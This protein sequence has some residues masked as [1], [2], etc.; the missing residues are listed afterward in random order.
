MWA[1]FAAH[2][3]VPGAAS[4]PL[5][6]RSLEQGYWV[7]RPGDRLR[8]IARRFFPGDRERTNALRNDL[9]ARNPNAFLRGDANA[10]IAG[11]KLSL[12]PALAPPPPARTEA[13]PVPA[14]SDAPR[15]APAPA[16]PSVAARPDD[17]PPIPER[18]APTPRVPAYLDRLIDERTGDDSPAAADRD[19]PPEPLGRRSLGVDLRTEFRDNNSRRIWERGIGV[20]Y[21]RETAL[22]GDLGIEADLR[23]AEVRDR[24]GLDRQRG[25][26]VTLYQ[27]RMPVSADW[28]ADNT[29]GVL[30]SIPPNMIGS[31]FRV[32]LPAP[33]LWGAASY[34]YTESM[35][36]FAYGGRAAR[37]SGFSTQEVDLDETRA[38]IFGV[39]HQFLPWLRLGTQANVFRID[40]AQP[41]RFSV[42]VAAETL[43]PA[44][45]TRVKFAG[46]GDDE[47]H[48]GFWLEGDAYQGFF[49]H[50]FGGY[51]FDRGLAYNAVP[52]VNDERLLYARTDYRTQ[53][54]S[55]S[56]ALDLSQTN[57]DRSA[58]RPGHTGTALFGNANL[59]MSRTITIGGSASVRHEEPRTGASIR[60]DLESET[61]F[62]RLSTAAGTSSF[63]LSRAAVRAEG[64]PSEGSTT[65]AWNHEWPAVW[66]V[67]VSTMLSRGKESS[68]RGEATRSVVGVTARAF[69]LTG[70]YFDTNLVGTRLERRT[71][72]DDNVNASVT[73]TWQFL[74]DWQ[75]QLFA[76]WNTSETSVAD[77]SHPSFRD[78]SVQLAVRYQKAR[79]VPIVPL[80]ARQPG[81]GGAGR[82]TGRVFFDE[83]GDGIRQPNERPAARVTLFLDGRFPVTTD[84]EGRFEFALVTAGLHSIQVGVET[85]PLPWGLAEERSLPV[86]V[87]V[88][89]DVVVEIGLKQIGP[90]RRRRPQG[91]TTASTLCSPPLHSTV[92]LR[93]SGYAKV[94]ERPSG[95]SFG[96]MGRVR[97][98]P[99]STGDGETENSSDLP[100]ASRASSVPSGRPCALPVFARVI[101]G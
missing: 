34:L 75:A 40:N 26:K 35:R 93:R 48:K 12:P 33:L 15:R 52:S 95:P 16:P 72:R 79:G 54:L 86:T 22:W 41:W 47:Q 2:A 78:K 30:R 9:F 24:A 64:L 46:L 65:L 36:A 13:A 23:D 63:D 53:R 55:Y 21:R 31:G 76:L 7:A 49:H 91:R 8:A 1:P 77:V 17:P 98:V 74:P 27:Y 71:G 6:R 101:E 83:N 56:L 68:A 25:G 73:A 84:S 28:L 18:A 66:G 45:R 96:Q 61:A 59:R 60:K 99:G 39:E 85:V 5:V 70:V 14:P 58:S 29:L 10:L 94:A 89:G 62:L 3:D 80:G 51:Q 32:N 43:F 19:E 88:R 44:R 67:N 50:R 92:P 81:T 82:I 38:G 87:P 42:A 37:L 90:G 57:L 4:D 11:A 97:V 69:P 20:A 100:S